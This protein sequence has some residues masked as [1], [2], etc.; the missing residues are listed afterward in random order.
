MIKSF[1]IRLLPTPEQ[2]A[3]L[4][5]HVNCARFAW[6]WGLAYQLEKHENGDK[7]LSGYDL[8]KCL[9][10]LKSQE[11]YQWLSNVSSH[12]LS[13]VIMDLDATYKHFF[14]KICGKP[15]F[16]KK[17]KS[18]SAFPVRQDNLYFKN[19]AANIE[20]IGKIKY[21]TNYDIPQGRNIAKFSNPRISY[22]GNKW[23]LSFGMECE[24]Q[25]LEL[26]DDSMGLDLGVKILVYVVCGDKHISY[27]N[28]NKTKR[29]KHLESKLRHLQ[30]NVSRKYETNNNT[31]RYEKKWH[32]SNAI[33]KCE[34]Q[35]AH[36]CRQLANIRKNYIHQT[37]AQ[38]IKLRPHHVVME[39]L[40]ISGM[41]KN[42]HL[43][44][45]IQ[46]QC[47]SEFIRQMRYKCEWNSIPFYQVDRFYPSS[48]TCS[49]CGSIKR[50]LKLKDRVFRCE[51][52]GSVI[53]R[54]ENAA[55]NLSNHPVA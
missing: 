53:D 52:C 16:K 18:K 4:W 22:V 9:L 15:K 38:L 30:R 2:E 41:M 49:V 51:D 32:K 54:D 40:N 33:L 47:L 37:T 21:Q 45:A 27:P 10:A 23:L 25:A 34:E 24:N 44:K 31:R 7:Y 6:N 36:I 17:S 55:I 39:D 46:K 43:S 48:K 20:K 42:R 35:I 14:K 13:V 8:R 28:I 50:D 3:L 5:N 1:K 11:E 26:T 12:M 29:V 19:N